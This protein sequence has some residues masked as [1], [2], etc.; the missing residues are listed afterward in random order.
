MQRQ[1]DL[2]KCYCYKL[3]TANKDGDFLFKNCADLMRTIGK[4]QHKVYLVHIILKHSC[5]ESEFEFA[6]L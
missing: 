3:W 2:M 1:L 4:Y 5:L 6:S